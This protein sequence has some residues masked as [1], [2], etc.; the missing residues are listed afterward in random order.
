MASILSPP[1]PA[2]LE[3]G[4]PGAVA[5]SIDAL[6]RSRLWRRRERT[7]ADQHYL[8]FI[9]YR[10]RDA[11]AIARW[12]RQRL[13]TFEP[14]EEL[15][16]RVKAAD[17]SVGG[18][19]NRVFLDT[20]YQRPQTNFWR[21]HIAPSVQR[22]DHLILVV[23]PS[24]FERLPN[25]EPNWVEREVETFLAAHDDPRRI[26]VVLGPGASERQLPEVLLRHSTLWDCV[27]LRFF[28]QSVISRFR[29]SAQYDAQ[30]GKIL[31]RLFEVPDGDLPALTR[32]FAQER[33]AAYRR[34]IVA[35]AVV[36]MGMAGLTLYALKERARAAAAEA[37]AIE[38]RD[39][40]VRQRNAALVAQSLYLTQT[41]E[42]YIAQGSTRMAVKLLRAALPGGEGSETRPLVPETVAAAYK[43][44]HG[45]REL[46]QVRLPERTGVVAAR[47]D[48]SA[49]A[50]VAPGRVTLIELPAGKPM[51]SFPVEPGSPARAL[52]SGAGRLLAL[53]G[54]G[55]DIRIYDTD[56]GRL[57][58]AHPGIGGGA[59]VRFVG[60]HGLLLQSADDK[61]LARLES[62][63]RLVA[64]R[65]FG[66]AFP[67][68]LGAGQGSV[69]IAADGEARRLSADDL[70][71]LVSRPIGPARYVAMTQGRGASAP[72]V[73]ASGADELSGS[74]AILDPATLAER[75]RFKLPRGAVTHLAVSGDGQMLAVHVP[76]TLIFYE[77]ATGFP[78][79]SH[80]TAATSGEFMATRR[81]GGY[82]VYVFSRYGLI[83]LVTPGY[84]TA[85][86]VQGETDDE[87]QAVVMD[88]DGRGFTSLTAAPSV[89][90][91]SRT[92]PAVR[93]SMAVRAAPDGAETFSFGF[94]LA[95]PFPRDPRL[96]VAHLDGRTT[97][98]DAASGELRQTLPQPARG[99]APSA[100][101]VSPDGALLARGATT[102]HVEVADLSKGGNRRLAL[103]SEPIRR[104]MFAGNGAILAQAADDAI[105][106]LPGPGDG[107][108]VGP[109]TRIGSCRSLRLGQKRA[110]CAAGAHLRVFDVGSGATLWEAPGAV[111]DQGEAL[112]AFLPRSDRVVAV[113]ASGVLGEWAED[114]TRLWT[115]P[116]TTVLRGAA[117]LDPAN[118]PLLDGAAREAIR[119]G[120]R[121]VTVRVPAAAIA[122]S[123]DR[124]VIAL[125]LADR[126]VQLLDRR[127]R[128]LRHALTASFPVR[129]LAWSDSGSQLAVLASMP[130]DLTIGLRRGELNVFDRSLGH[131]IHSNYEVTTAG[132]QLFPIAGRQGFTVSAPP[133]V[134][135]ALPFF[136]D[137][138]NLVGFLQQR[139]PES[140]TPAQRRAYHL[141]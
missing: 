24:I 22:S 137:H 18:R 64:S 23:T 127:E 42:R 53:V 69:L 136:E 44:L 3:N 16:E 104:V 30:L 54:H 110:A 21:D 60:E 8:A 59:K 14:P 4:P 131:V 19:H 90:R 40:A 94:A 5:R 139:Y 140:L 121:E 62:S 61:H 35:G 79:T 48:G 89:T 134:L 109:A 81:G 58:G 125:A 126:T 41:A 120:A 13:G 96:A 10:R 9:S 75:R 85:T 31:A 128:K 36:L 32:E 12:L 55:G 56:S 97:I 72:V 78:L 98:W 25:G 105:Y 133:L 27:D 135:A 99:A 26:L 33:A 51:R 38:Q 50:A 83:S 115:L 20:S 39:E 112:I 52:F 28:S 102:G 123:P 93:R 114:G 130:V 124:G 86:K 63:G 6:T 101:A 73:L 2:A 66:E 43:A 7:G 84:D 87:V 108:S 80:D 77:L 119:S 34:V 106:R 118:A 82:E 138:M 88:A 129:E 107:A 17:Q 100:L 91:W 29:R 46:G 132:S 76:A 45:D 141:D 11:G 37:L 68:F 95:A 71:D 116:L 47:H 122:P 92:D 111:A 117:L 103:G 67:I 74:I 57:V 113:D 15:A 49:L 70:R 1:R 65:S